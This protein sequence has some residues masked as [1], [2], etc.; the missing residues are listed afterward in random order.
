MRLLI[1]VFTGLV[2]LALPPAPGWA[3]TDLETMRTPEI[4]ALQHRLADAGCYTAEIDGRPSPATAAAVKACPDQSPMLRIETGMHVAQI[5]RLDVDA[6]CHLMATASDDKTLRLWSLPEGRLL[7][8]IR[9]PIDDGDAGK[10]YAVALSP[11]RHTIAAGGFT[12]QWDKGKP[13]SIYVIDSA[14]GAMQRYGDFGSVANHLAFSADG[15]RLGIA[16]GGTKGVRVLDPSTGRELMSDQDYGSDAYGLAFGPDGSMVTTSYDGYLRRYGPDFTLTAKVKAPGGAR[17]YGIAVDP[18]GRWVAV[19]YA[20]TTAIS[21]L[22]AAALKHFTRADTADV[23]T[24]NLEVVAWTADGR[25]LLAGGET[26]KPIDG[27]WYRYVRRF[28]PNGRRIGRDIGV[29]DNT[30]MDLKPCAGDV[31]FTAADPSFGL[32]DPNGRARVLQG[33][34]TA[35]MR[36]KVGA[37][38]L[39]LSGDAGTVRFGLGDGAERPVLFDLSAGRL[40][41]SPN[42]PAGVTAPSMAGL[43]IT[44]WKND[45]APKLDGAPIPL[46]QY[47]MSRSLALRLDR[48]GFVLGADWSL[49]SFDAAGKQRWNRPVPSNT[50]GVDLS[51]DG[52]I[53]V[54]AYGDGTI[55]WHRWSDGQEL[56]ALFV[57]RNTRAWVAWTPTGYYMA[58]AGAE[59]LIGWHVNRGWEQEADFFPA[60]RFRDKFNRPDIVQT[61][62]R[63]LDEGE[64]VKQANA[65][66]KRRDDQTP[67]IERLPPVITILSPSDGAGV[68]PGMVEI[69][70]RTRTPSGGKVDRIEAF[71]DGAK[72]QAR[73]LGPSAGAAPDPDGSTAVTLPMPSHDAVIS[74]VAYADGKASDEARD[75]T[76]G[77]GDDRHRRVGRG[78]RVCSSRLSTPC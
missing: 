32:V 52:N 70:Y 23:K 43:R 42:P 19:G 38:A 18:S 77:D 13:L 21:I 14:S 30:I 74:L 1:R 15:S 56:L 64:A 53:I 22:D 62:L 20:D 48:E 51:Q 4:E 2:V 31:A 27:Q 24:D 29:S 34:V 68:A 63:T 49:R 50:W 60:S 76:Q 26:S 47:E 61:I 25:E 37:T 65:A 7:R 8:T 41:D 57:N 78:G 40:T 11:D 33:P 75:R 3:A 45:V 54:A 55:R 71:V 17:P 28:A 5:S 46:Q 69:R 58:S 36:D 59:D 44:D 10:V 6:G 9:L 16:L 35:D 67:I 72:I 39:M 73:G 12:G 66:A